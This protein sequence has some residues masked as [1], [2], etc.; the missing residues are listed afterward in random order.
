MRDVRLVPIGDAAPVTLTS[1]LHV[2][3]ICGNRLSVAQLA[4]RGIS[5]HIGAEAVTLFRAGA[6]LAGAR[7]TRHAFV[8]P[9]AL[10][11]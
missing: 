5:V 4:Q 3:T 6:V 11:S 8:L 10:R 9:T 1:V 7:F 2:R